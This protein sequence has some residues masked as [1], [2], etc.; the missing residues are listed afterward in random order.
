MPDEPNPAMDPANPPRPA[1]PTAAPPSSP[2]LS[3]F[4]PPDFR[5]NDP[6]GHAAQIMAFVEGTTASTLHRASTEQDPGVRAG[7]IEALN[8]QATKLRTAA[9]ALDSAIEAAQD[10]PQPEPGPGPQPAPAPAT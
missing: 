8:F 5:S 9:E 4:L 10:G 1:A 7:L 3:A 2:S 6:F